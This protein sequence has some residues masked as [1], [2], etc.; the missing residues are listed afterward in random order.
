MFLDIN[1]IVKKAMA[2][3]PDPPAAQQA[4]IPETVCP[5]KLERE[6]QQYVL[7]NRPTPTSKSYKYGLKLFT[8][9]CE[10]KGFAPDTSSIGSL[11]ACMRELLERGYSESTINNSVC[12][13]VADV[14]RHTSTRSPTESRLVVDMKKIVKRKTPA[15]KR[16][17]QIPRGKCIELLDHLNL[18]AK[19][20]ARALHT[21]KLLMCLR[22]ALMFLFVYKVWTRPD[23]A[24]NLKRDACEFSDFEGKETLMVHV[25]GGKNNP[26]RNHTVLLCAGNSPSLNILEWLKRYQA[27]EE[28]FWSEMGISE[29][30]ATL[31]YNLQTAKSKLLG[32]NLKPPTINSRLKAAGLR[33]SPP[34]NFPNGGMSVYGLRVAG[35]SRAIK[36]K[37]A[38]HLVKRHGNWSSDAVERYICEEDEERL[39]VSECL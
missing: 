1:T 29:R 13:S 4:A 27:A 25:F 20:H 31:F 16:R 39:K 6:L 38:M 17:K 19:S 11:A 32:G 14:H 23:Q 37:V 28:L 10:E 12:S 5:A 30:P 24:V 15:P 33:M 36:S 18:E 9:V 2:A 3:I 7:D 8:E 34:F 21:R 35:V 22:D 26:G